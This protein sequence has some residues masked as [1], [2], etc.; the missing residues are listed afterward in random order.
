MKVLWGALVV[1]GRGKL[2]GHVASKNGAGSYFRTKV[3][4]TNPQSIAQSAV[5]ALF[6]VI[7]QGWSALSISQ[8]L[9]WNGAVAQWQKTD[10]F[11]NLKKLSG[12]ALYQRLNNQ[13]QV[14]GFPAVTN[15]PAIAEMPVGVIEAAVFSIGDGEIVIQGRATD[16]NSNTILFA[17][18]SLSS[19]TSFVKN[20]LRVIL[21]QASTTIAFP[22]NAYS[23]YVDKFGVPVIGQNIFVAVKYV[24]DNGQ[25]SVIQ[26]IKATV[27][28]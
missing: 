15:P 1:D 7:S 24:L 11:G 9:A 17:T 8:R 23:G 25:A 4:P 5:R 16:A 10:V 18:P 3:T 27:V 20:R 26:T 12:K 13:A 6:A 28:A 22:A 21:A 14:A 19:G 2:G